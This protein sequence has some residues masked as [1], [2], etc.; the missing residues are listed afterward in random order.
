MGVYGSINFN[1][2]LVDISISIEC[3]LQI[4]NLR[5]GM[6]SNSSQEAAIQSQISSSQSKKI[7]ADNLS[8]VNRAFKDMILRAGLTERNRS[9]FVV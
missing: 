2:H 8:Q 3:N 9:L 1:T 5:G 4:V 7:D 6:M